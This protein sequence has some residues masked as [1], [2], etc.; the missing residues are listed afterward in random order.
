[1][2]HA[3]VQPYK[4]NERRILPKNLHPLAIILVLNF[5]KALKN[6]ACPVVATASNSPLK[7]Y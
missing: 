5:H 2:K 7:L 3:L 1:M 4:I 6:Y